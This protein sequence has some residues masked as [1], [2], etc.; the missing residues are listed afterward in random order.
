MKVAEI[1]KRNGNGFLKLLKSISKSF[2]K[3]FFEDINFGAPW[4]FSKMRI[5]IKHSNN[6]RL[7]FKG[8]CFTLTNKSQFYKNSFNW[9]SQSKTSII[10]YH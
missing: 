2:K 10:I 7:L 8:T 3:S 1:S 4:K 9:E 5:T 6:S